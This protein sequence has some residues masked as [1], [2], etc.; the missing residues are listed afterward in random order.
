MSDTGICSHCGLH[1]ECRTGHCPGNYSEERDAKY[2]ATQVCNEQ[3]EAQLRE[4]QAHC[5]ALK[6][7]LQDSVDRGPPCPC[8]GA[9]DDETESAGLYPHTEGCIAWAALALPSGSEF[10][11]EMERLRADRDI[12]RD[13]KQ[14]YSRERDAL[15]F[16]NGTLERKTEQQEASI[17]MLLAERDA[18]KARSSELEKAHVEDQVLWHRT[19]HERDDLKA[20]ET[21][22]QKQTSGK[23][24]TFCGLKARVAELEVYSKVQ[25]ANAENACADVLRAWREREEALAKVKELQAQVDA[26]KNEIAACNAGQDACSYR[27]AFVPRS[28]LEKAQKEIE[29]QRS[30][31]EFQDFE[32]S[33]L[34]NSEKRV[35]AA[36]YQNRGLQEAQQG[37]Q[38]LVCTLQSKLA[39]CVETLKGLLVEGK[40]GR[41]HEPDCIGVHGYDCKAWCAATRELLANAAPQA[42]ARDRRLRDEAITECAEHIA[43]NCDDDDWRD[44]GRER[45]NALKS[46]AGES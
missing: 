14:S 31:I 44:W 3:L 26:L 35:L 19:K 11:V 36:E 8:C 6:E 24:E 18:Q 41:K 40:D 23:L 16:R 46:K 4:A 30:V 25:T 28:E 10:L 39:A 21:E 38:E 12:Q 7:A 33:K 5:A 1:K 43:N 13:A 9:E 20:R 2:M 45:L 22:C 15:K 37:L 42:E 29:R 32:T 17:S 27:N 34:V